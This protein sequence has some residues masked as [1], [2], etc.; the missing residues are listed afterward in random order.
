MSLGG[1]G[2]SLAGVRRNGLAATGFENTEYKFTVRTRF[3]RL[4]EEVSAPDCTAR[5][6]NP[7]QN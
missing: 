1:E 2:S 5:V 4:E 6:L 7:S 3:D